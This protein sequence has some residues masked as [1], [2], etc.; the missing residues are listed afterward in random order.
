MSELIEARS[1]FKWNEVRP[2]EVT[3]KLPISSLEISKS[4]PVGRTEEGYTP[5]FRNK[6]LKD[7]VIWN[8][9]RD[10]DTYDKLFENAVKCYGDRPCLGSREYDY[11]K[12][13]S[14]R[15]FKSYTYKEVD[16]RR[17][18]LG[19]GILGILRA[20]PYKLPDSKVH[21]KIDQHE[22]N[23]KGYCEATDNYEENSSFVVSI[24]SSN[25]LEWMLTDLACSAYSL[26]NTALYDTLGVGA[27]KHILEITGSPIVVCSRD[28]I[29]T[30][31]SLKRSYPNELRNV[32]SIVSMDPLDIA[33]DRHLVEQQAKELNITIHDIRE[34]EEFGRLHPLKPLPPS[35]NTLYTISFTS[36]TTGANPKGVMLTQANATAA[37]T[38][39]A[40]SMSQLENGKA[41]IFLPLTHIYERK[42]SGFAL[43]TGYF[44]GFPQLTVEQDPKKVNPFENLLDDLSIFKP[45]YLS[46]VPRILLRI[47]ALIK[48][49]LKDL[50]ASTLAEVD[51]ILEYKLTQQLYSDGSQGNHEIYDSHPEYKNLRSLVGFQNLVW[52]QTASAPISPSTIVYLKS[53]LN[54]GLKQL[55][56]LTETF[57]ALTLSNAYESN[58]GSCGGI[59]P[60]AEMRLRE[61]PGMNYYSKDLKGELLL[62]GPQLFKGYYRDKAETEKAFDKDGWFLTGDI[63]RIDP[64][65]G[66]LYIIDRVKNFFKLS[67]GEYVSPEKVENIYLSANPVLAQLYVHGD[68]MTSYVIG[69][70]GIEFSKAAAFLR[71]QGKLSTSEP[72]REDVYKLINTPQMK[73]ALLSKCN[74]N[75]R[76]K[77]NGFE[78]IRNIYI[79]ENPLT[80]DRNVVTPT[81]KIKRAIAS[82]FF[83]DI[84]DALYKEGS[85][86]KLNSKV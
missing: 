79:E 62:R 66:R 36:G 61:I 80:L 31:L 33:F 57:G 56:G 63:A 25:R 41:F 64:K 18:N 38:F 58:P 8:L 5:I 7:R 21:E 6:V 77:L 19:A 34:V 67:Q 76:N 69:I 16:I 3:S 54:I 28:K 9:H 35:A 23:F 73:A 42:T 75:V 85:I 53:A 52:T 10:L 74:S 22:K 48:N 20:N 82:V 12:K 40:C 1:L 44:L 78:L 51:E 71:E 17:K 30:V 70:A 45:T 2:E 39:L 65:T 50:D 4:V 47:E 27:S 37:V 49:K 15:F 13:V 29:S 24:F 72:T 11:E 43:S 14:G 55:Y 86:L 81:M 46:L 83:K 84:I 59:G 32:I 26:V 68:S 60:C